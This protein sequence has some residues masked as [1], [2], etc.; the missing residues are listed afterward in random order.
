MADNEIKGGMMRGHI[1]TIILLSLVDGDKDSNDIRDA[2][3]EKSDNKYSVKQG[4]FYSAM[5][6]LV[7]QNYIKEY[8][9]SAVDGIR[10]KYYSLTAKGKSS[11]DKNREEWNKSKE[12]IDN[13]IET[14][15]EQ[16]KDQENK[17]TTIADEFAAFKQFADKNASDFEF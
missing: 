7:K 8:R 10:R 4:T 11:L 14:P 13:L 2:I 5:Q 12:L 3:E 15:S 6:R 9:S 1:D 16:P 17:P